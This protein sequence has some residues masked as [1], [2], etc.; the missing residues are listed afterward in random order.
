MLKLKVLDWEVQGRRTSMIAEAKEDGY[1]AVMELTKEPSGKRLPLKSMWSECL[2]CPASVDIRSEVAAMA[3]VLKIS[4]P[5][6]HAGVA[7]K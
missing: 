6:L 2:Q 1:S 5:H 3:H 4:R 7:T